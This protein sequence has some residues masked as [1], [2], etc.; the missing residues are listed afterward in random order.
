MEKHDAIQKILSAIQAQGADI[1]NVT[2]GV[3]WMG[4]SSGLQQQVDEA[5]L[6][7]TERGDSQPLLGVI[8]LLQTLDIFSASEAAEMYEVIGNSSGKEKRL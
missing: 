3:G 4:Q 5:I 2:N 1:L 7:W 8:E 6:S